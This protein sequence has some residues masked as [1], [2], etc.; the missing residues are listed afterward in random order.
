MNDQPSPPSPGSVN[1]IALGIT[2]S[3][4]SVYLLADCYYSIFIYL[5]RAI[6]VFKSV[7]VHVDL[8][9]DLMAHYGKILWALVALCTVLSIVVAFRRPGHRRTVAVQG[10]TFV[11]ALILIFLARHAVWSSFVGLLQ[12]VG[13]EK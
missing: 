1:L 2:C 10:A 7:K 3:V 9:T 13:T 11:S 8:V 12:G 5:P 6:D 4:V